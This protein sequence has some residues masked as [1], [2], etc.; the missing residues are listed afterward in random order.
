MTDISH[1]G[2]GFRVEDADERLQLAVDIELRIMVSYIK[3]EV[4]LFG[5]VAWCR[6]NEDNLIFGIE[7]LEEPENIAEFTTLDLDHVKIDPAW[8]LRIPPNLA[9]RRQLLAF[10]SLD[11]A[12]YIACADPGDTA[13]LQAVERYVDKIVRPVRA[14]P[15]SL[16]RAL[17]RI[18]GDNPAAA[19]SGK[20][21]GAG[22]DVADEADPVALCDELLHAAYLRQASDIHIDPGRDGVRI[23]FRVDGVLEDFRLV[24]IEA[25]AEMLSRFKVMSGMDI[26]ERRSPQD[27]RFTHELGPGRTGI[28]IRTATLL[29]K[30][31]ERMT[32]RLL[33]LQTASLTL[34]RLGMSEADRARFESCIEKPHGILLVTGPTGSGKTTTLYAALRRVI[35]SERLNVITIE[36]PIEYDIPGVAQVEVDAVDKVSFS[37]ALRSVLRHDPDVVMIGEIR[38]QETADIAIKA[39]LTG[40]LVLSTLHTNSAASAM[41]RLVDMGIERYRIAATL[42]LAMAQRL[43]RR[44]CPHCRKRRTLLNSEACAL[45]R[46]ELEGRPV[47]EPRGCIYCAG[48]GF[49]GRIGIYEMLPVDEKFS[50]L[51]AR[52]AEEGDIVDAMREQKLAMLVDDAIEKLL[53][54]ETS[55]KEVLGAV[56]AS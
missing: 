23:R 44:L 55:L 26:A 5:R 48:K 51:I 22:T 36:D 9:V 15:D 2:A 45:N 42:R 25:H 47:Y 13:A 37:K 4:G 40:H 14:T 43:V 24:P 35:E 19:P 49:S 41:T 50:R 53:A 11:D 6:R 3:G 18:Y 54:G 56:T 34:E 52:G 39:S 38:D 1:G 33:A 17:S 30:Y 16:K 20:R 7:F 10:V 21:A 8:A 29:T 12:V 32:L 27:G 46:P 28:D 31:G